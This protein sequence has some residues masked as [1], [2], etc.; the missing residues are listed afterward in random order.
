MSF[1]KDTIS[2][3]EITQPLPKERPNFSSGPRR[4]TPQEIESLRQD[5]QEAG[6]IARE[7][8]KKLLGK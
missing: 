8:F 4:L 1:F 5:R 7:H 6:K 3:A 2:T